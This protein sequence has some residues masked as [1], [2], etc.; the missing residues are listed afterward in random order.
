MSPMAVC[1][2]ANAIAQRKKRAESRS[3]ALHPATMSFNSRPCR[4]GRVQRIPLNEAS[5]IFVK[6]K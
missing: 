2:A 4:S 3:N 6:K 5:L 1:R